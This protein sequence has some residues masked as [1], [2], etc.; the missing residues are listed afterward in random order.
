MTDIEKERAMFVRC[1]GMHTKAVRDIVKSVTEYNC[2]FVWNPFSCME[3]VIP[4]FTKGVP[5]QIDAL[6]VMHG[7]IA[8][9]AALFMTLYVGAYIGGYAPPS[10]KYDNMRTD[11]SFGYYIGIGCGIINII[12]SILYRAV[13]LCILRILLSGIDI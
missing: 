7:E 9:Y 11:S 13:R 4:A 10:S 1:S 5:Q 6:C 12:T 8:V 2:C 3:Y